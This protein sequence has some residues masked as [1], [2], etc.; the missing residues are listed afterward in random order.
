MEITKTISVAMCTYN[1][2][3]FLKEQLESISAQTLLPDELIIC[4]DRSSDSTLQILSSFGK[5][6]SFPV[7]IIENPETLRVTKNFENAIRHCT[8][9]IIVLAD[10]DD[11]W[12]PGKLEN[13]IGAFRDHP[14]CGYVF[15]N[16]ELTDETGASRETDLWQSIGFDEVRV[17]KYMTGD[18]LEVMLRGG[19]FV[20]GMAMA[21]RST[22]NSSLLPIES[23]SDQ[24]LHDRWIP[25]ML[26]A[27]GAYGVAVR[28]L[29][30]KYRQHEA[31]VLGGEIKPLGFGDR[32]RMIRASASQGN[33]A[34][35]DALMIIATRVQRD[36]R[37]GVH[38]LHAMNQLTDKATHLRARYLANSSRGLQRLGLVF[39]ETISGRYRR[40]SGGLP[41]VVRD[42]FAVP[43]KSADR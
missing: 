30:V 23:K 38:E 12:H 39:R 33:P 4:D 42:L 14:D 8:G 17:R 40:F 28:D 26:S 29:L 27:K 2:E 1:G 41:S 32:L 13:L 3:A 7:R 24:C 10:Q 20:S 35:A 34:L 16:A 22:F 5:T 19:N 25:L 6:C 9:E 18:Q 31:Q 37:N 11:I 36:S 15:S 43:M 21:F